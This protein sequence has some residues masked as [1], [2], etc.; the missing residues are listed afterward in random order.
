[1]AID[2]LKV[3]GTRPIRPDGVDKVIGRAAFGADMVMPGM[4]WGKI[5]R[6]PHAHARILSIDTSKARALPGVKAVVTAADFPS[7]PSEEAFMGEGPM[8]FR[9]LSRNCMAADKVLYDGHAVAAVAATSQAIAEEAVELIDVKYEVLPHVI[10]VEAAMAPDA[11]ILHEDLFTSGVE[12]KPTKPS[13]IAK[14]VGFTKGDV[15]AGFKEAEVVIERRYTTQ[16]VHQAYIEPHAC[17]VSAAPDGQ[18]TIWSSSQGQFMVR[19]YCAKLLGIDIANI[20]VVPAEIGGGFGGKTL[21]Y[22]EPVALAL[23][24]QAG[25]PVKIVMSREEVFRGTGPAAG[26]VIEVKLGAKRDGRI[27]AAELLL[28]YQAGAF[29]GSPVG[30]G[31]MCAFAMYDLPNVNIVGYDV[32]SNR[33]KVAAYRA[34]GAPN[35]SFGVESCLD[36]LARMLKIDPL[37]LRE[38]NAAKD[39]TKTAHG[40]TFTN[41]GYVQTV[42]AA[43]NHPHYKAPLGPNQGRGVA[44]GFWFN[45]GGESSAA[46][47]INE[48]GTATVVEGNPDIGGSRASM[49]MMAAEVLGIPYDRVRPVVGDTSSIGFTFLTGGSRVTFATGMAV[50][51]AA[52]KVVVELKKRAAMIWDISP[53]AVE[54]KDG[55]AVPAGANAGNFEPLSLAEI[56]LKSGRTGGPISAEVSINAQGAGPGFATHICDVEVD[57]ETGH[58]KILRYTAIQDVGR[59]IHPSY[60][61]GQI[62]GGV[63]Q[64]IGWAL[65]EEYIYDKDGRLDNAGFLDYRIPVASDM[66]MIEPV[67]IEV[68]NPRHPFG[69]RGVGEVPIVP[70]M[71]AV[72]NAIADATGMRMRDLPISPPKLRAAL[73]AGTL[74][75]AAE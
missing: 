13:N 67:M 7:I 55:Y 54:W 11:P 12:P 15:A 38:I 53:E 61:E 52:E 23:S 10:D 57:P 74:K 19:A 24:K 5:K 68:P 31:C 2:G 9:D 62:Q 63:A 32:V 41:I 30:P 46:C 58:V 6:S 60:V 71:A 45:I 28:K 69:A 3:V 56:A 37:R 34:P 29:P 33:P 49:A 70:P 36:E 27:V 42:E 40:P 65:N 59:A 50:T 18:C 75:E 14:K 47:H 22:L 25:R 21:V 1:M 72:A 51:Q 8:N 39:G 66:P 73:D 48:D 44:S 4:L 35:S 64:G 17:V 26:S 20:R 16:P 43:K